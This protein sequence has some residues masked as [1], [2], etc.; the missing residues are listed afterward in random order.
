MNKRSHCDSLT[1]PGC[2]G[3]GAIAASVA[4]F[5]WR[6]PLRPPSLAAGK[7]ADYYW[8]M[9]SYCSIRNIR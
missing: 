3:G 8:S 6:L 2:G 4:G 1:G 9:D 5:G 7:E